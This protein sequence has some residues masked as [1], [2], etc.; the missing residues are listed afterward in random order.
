M[1]KMTP[2]PEQ[3][4]AINEMV[5][6]PAGINASDPGTGKTLMGV[7]VILRTWATRSL[8]IAPHS[9]WDNWRDTIEAQSEGTEKFLPCS[10]SKISE[11]TTAKECKANLEALLRGD[12]GHYFIGREFF[13]TL[14]WETVPDMDRKTKQQKVDEKTGKPKTKRVQKRVWEKHPFEVALFDESH[15]AS[16][17]KSRG[18]LTWMRLK[19]SHKFESSGTWFGNKWENAWAAANAVY[20]DDVTDTYWLW[21][22]RWCATEYDHFA[23][24][25]TKVTGEKVPGAF[26]KSLPCYIQLKSDQEHPVPEIRW[27]DLSREQRKV[28]RELVDEMVT[29]LNDHPLVVEATITQ[30]T[31]L[32]QVTLGEIAFNDDGDV[33]F[34]IDGRSTKYDELLSII[35]EFPDEQMV[36][37]SASARFAEV[38]TAKLNRDLKGEVAG[39]WA[40]Q[41]RTSAKQRDQLKADF[42]SG[43]VR[44]I[45][46]VIT[47][48][49]TG[50][51][52]LQTVCNTMV[53]L[54]EQ[55][56]QDS[57]MD[58]LYHRLARRGQNKTVRFIKIAA[59]NTYDQGV[60]DQL[61]T[62]ALANNLSRRK[63]LAGA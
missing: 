58:Q 34:H 10:N 19:A 60:L 28:Y 62:Q 14:D 41:K 29:F 36:I 44:Y 52:G 12:D 63:S 16:S 24:R 31:R 51:D 4:A 57:T 3:E 32:R 18:Y 50:V 38:V 33:D 15:V 25:Q 37:V 30:R 53:I 22:G 1:Q 54:E 42:L 6:S 56:G 7:E 2:S 11:D 23:P 47:A 5:N 21:Q 48:M 17:A 27:V 35:K 39:L 9:T 13:V 59:R 20:G 55:E 40:G 26:V 43:K 61:I 45:V 8:V 46:G 49:G